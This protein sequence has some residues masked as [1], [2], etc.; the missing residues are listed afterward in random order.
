M[1]TDPWR[2][3]EK[4]AELSHH[5]II[6]EQGS[7][8]CLAELHTLEA[9]DMFALEIGAFLPNEIFARKNE[10]G[11]YRIMK[12]LTEETLGENDRVATTTLVEVTATE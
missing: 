11:S 5:T 4:N 6:I 3:R 8:R 10:L 9:D 12:R 1:A 2:V 7:G